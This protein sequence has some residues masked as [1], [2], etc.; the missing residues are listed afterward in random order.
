MTTKF[1]WP[2]I[3]EVNR[4]L[5]NMYRLWN[6]PERLQRAFSLSVVR[7]KTPQLLFTGILF[8]GFLRRSRFLSMLDSFRSENHQ[9]R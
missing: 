4:S 8:Q 9:R 3:D 2:L 5:V 7:F 1:Y 6:P